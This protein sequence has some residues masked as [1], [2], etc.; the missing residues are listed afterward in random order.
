MMDHDFADAKHKG[1]LAADPHWTAGWQAAFC[2]TH[3]QQES[4]RNEKTCSSYNTTDTDCVWSIG[5]VVFGEE[6]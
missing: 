6:R 5:Q 1:R 2:I 3:R 4:F